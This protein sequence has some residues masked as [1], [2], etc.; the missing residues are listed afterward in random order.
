MYLDLRSEL[1]CFQRQS[2][3]LPTEW[4]GGGEVGREGGE[5]EGGR[6]GGR[7]EGRREG[8]GWEGDE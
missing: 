1:L 8:G 4:V 5:K 7:R 6:E 3:I 2:L